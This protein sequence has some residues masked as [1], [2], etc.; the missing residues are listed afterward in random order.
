MTDKLEIP[1]NMTLVPLPP[2]SQELNGQEN[3]WQ[4]L[5][6]NYLSNRICKDYDA[7]LD[8]AEAAWKSL[9]SMPDKIKSIAAKSWAL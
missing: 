6:D 2:Y 3:I 1:E 8:A 9:V 7:I 5:R 4:Y